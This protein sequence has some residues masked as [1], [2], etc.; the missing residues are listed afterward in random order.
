ML[1]VATALVLLMKGESSCEEAR[2]LVG[3]TVPEEPARES[4]GER[5]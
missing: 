5:F 1:L 3:D 4:R 2:E